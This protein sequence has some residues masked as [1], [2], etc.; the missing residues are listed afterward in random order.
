MPRTSPNEAVTPRVV[1][2]GAANVRA[3][4]AVAQVAEGEFRSA[5]ATPATGVP[6]VPKMTNDGYTSPICQIGFAMRNW[7]KPGD[8][9]GT[10]LWE[11]LRS[12]FE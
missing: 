1:D 3:S 8:G 6:S 9:P 4:P 12:L 2:Q 5:G 11:L 7:A 10:K